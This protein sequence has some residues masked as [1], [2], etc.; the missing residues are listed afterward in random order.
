V[1]VTGAA[2]SGKAPT[3][4]VEV[5]KVSGTVVDAVSEMLAQSD[6]TTAELLTKEIGVRTV[7]EGS[8]AAGV[9]AARDAL[10]KAG[11]PTAGVSVVDGSGLDRSNTLTCAFLVALLDRN[12][13]TSPVA[14]ALPVAGK[15]GTLA[16]RFLNTI[17]TGRIRA[18]T[19]SLRNSRALA[20]FA[21]AGKGTDVHTLTFAYIANQ[22]NLNTDA[23][24]KV[25]DQL[26]VGL[27]SYPQAPTLSELGPR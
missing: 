1:R 23:N 6:N 25:Q 9:A 17:A 8:T 13:P 27:A 2:R 5:A 7:G 22:T 10:T 16:E 26:G 14:K 18:K 24:L 3:P 15:S 19:G 4:T 20:G 21:D 12:G 11:L